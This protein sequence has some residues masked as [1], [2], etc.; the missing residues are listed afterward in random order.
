MRFY[1]YEAKALFARHGL[2]LVRRHVVHSDAQAREAAVELDAEKMVVL[3][4]VAAGTDPE[5]LSAG[6]EVELV[7]ET[8][9]ED[10][11]NEYLVWKWKPVAA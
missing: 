8:L 2:P 7:L 6:S 1:E 4:Q 5:E 3:G 9:Y 11:E 10:D